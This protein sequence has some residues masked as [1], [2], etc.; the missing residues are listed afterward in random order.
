M[1]DR[2]I[3]SGVKCRAFTQLPKGCATG[4]LLSHRTSTTYLARSVTSKTMNRSP[5]AFAKTANAF[6]QNSKTSSRTTAPKRSSGKWSVASEEKNTKRRTSSTSRLT[7]FRRSASW[8][9]IQATT[10][11]S[12]APMSQLVFISK[13]GGNVLRLPFRKGKW[14][15]ERIREIAKAQGV[16]G[17]QIVAIANSE[18]EFVEMK[19]LTD[20]LAPAG[21][22]RDVAPMVT[23]VEMVGE[24]KA[25]IS[26]KY[27]RAVAKVG[28][29][30]FLKYFPLFSGLEPELDGI[31][32]YIYEGKADRLIVRPVDEPFLRDLQQNG[33]RLNKWAHLLSAE[34]KE[35]GI[36]ARMQFFAGPEVNPI[37]WSVVFTE[38][39]QKYIQTTGHVFAYFD[40]PRDGYD[41]VRGDL[42]SVCD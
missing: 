32:R 1:L 33:A 20:A 36:E 27:L 28:F 26:E 35:T 13:D 31:K 29:H 41:G 17:E 21:Q 7:A 5:I 37:V 11:K 39:P 9:N 14:T 38:K 19:A 10:S 40:E 42:I 18:E 34:S 2:R 23:G 22:E 15:V 4:K 16:T 3:V 8:E 12:C 6:A 24:M 25:P 30:F